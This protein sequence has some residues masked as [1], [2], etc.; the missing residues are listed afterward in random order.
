VAALIVSDAGALAPILAAIGGACGALW[1]FLGEKWLS[2]LHWG[3]HDCLKPI[4][5]RAERL[6]AAGR[7]PSEDQLGQ[8]D[9]DE[10]ACNDAP[11]RTKPSN[12]HGPQATT[13]AD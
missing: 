12:D 2:E 7:D 10:L 5:N 11:R 3:R 13:A 6:V 8:L 4:A 9:T 1:G